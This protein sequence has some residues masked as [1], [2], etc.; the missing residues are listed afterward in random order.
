MYNVLVKKYLKTNSITGMSSGFKLIGR[1]G[2]FCY[3]I[4]TNYRNM[5]VGWSAVN[6]FEQELKNLS[7]NTVGFI[8]TN[9]LYSEQAVERADVSTRKILLC[10]EN[11]IMKTI[12]DYSNNL[13]SQ[14]KTS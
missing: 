2:E 3:M 5:M 8:V 12:H 4:K 11:N 14:F 9:N 1:I 10:N 7:D 13:A 6:K